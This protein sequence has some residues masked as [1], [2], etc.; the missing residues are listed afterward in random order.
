MGRIR[1]ALFLCVSATAANTGGREH[2]SVSQDGSRIAFVSG[3][4]VYVIRADGT[5]QVQLTQTPEEEAAPAWTRR[6]KVVYSTFANNSSR[7]FMIDP[8]GRNGR[9]IAT[10]P[11]RGPVLSP[12]ESRVIYWTGSWT[13][14]RLL[15]ATLDGSA[16][17][18]ITDG[19]SIAWNSQWS[20]DGRRIAYTGRD[21]GGGLHVFVMNADGS[22][23]RQ[24]THVPAGEG[25]AQVP[26]W[27]PDGHQ[28]AFQT[29]PGPGKPGHVW[30][31]DA[32]TGVARK[33]AVHT[34]PF[35]DEVPSWFPDGKRLAFQS[36]RTRR[37]EIW[38]VNANGSD[39]RQL[40]R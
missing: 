40:T 30:I 20:P 27:S 38:V 6:G 18:Q 12:D 25:E 23:P 31:A 15:V 10:V 17:H 19:S 24:L 32:E 16:V 2:P 8:D 29:T 36:N 21:L 33:I 14:T 7:L 34:Q 3:G 5:G 39:P 4:D 35:I 13:S 1:L 9:V 28:I 37:M 11:G 22:G 26:A